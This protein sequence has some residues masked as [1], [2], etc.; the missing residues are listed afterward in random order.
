MST[1]EVKTEIV[2]Q[3]KPAKQQSIADWLKND[4]LKAEIAKAIP[5]HLNAENMC[6]V[7]LTIVNKTPDLQKCTTSSFMEAFMLCAQWGLK[8]NGYH[9]HL[10]PYRDNKLNCHRVQLILDYKGLIQ[11]AYNSGFV[12]S[13]NAQ[14]VCENDQFE[15][16][17]GSVVRHSVNRKGERGDVYAVYCVIELKDGAQHTEIMSRDD[18][19][20]IRKRSKA[21]NVGPWQT[22]WDEMAK[23]TVFR[24]ASKWI[25]VSADIQELMSKD[26]DQF[27]SRHVAAEPATVA[28]LESILGEGESREVAS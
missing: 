17:M 13:I 20:A 27:E 8:P 21:G 22:D 10:I 5:Q 4:S 19:E 24:R 7:A 6:R 2:E 14:I 26:D 15:E 18:V 23:K 12:K 16:N 28:H 3:R 25:P 1:A 9:A 11:L